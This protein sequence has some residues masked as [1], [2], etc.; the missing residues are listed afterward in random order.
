MTRFQHVLGNELMRAGNVLLSG[1]RGLPAA[2][3]EAA[4]METSDDILVTKGSDWRGSVTMRYSTVRRGLSV[5]ACHCVSG[6]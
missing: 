2:S 5:A 3:E 1:A 6:R 4:G